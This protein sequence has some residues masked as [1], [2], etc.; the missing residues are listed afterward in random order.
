MV[1]AAS[2]LLHCLPTAKNRRK[3]KR[4]CQLTKILF[5]NPELYENDVSQREF[6]IIL[7]AVANDSKPAKKRKP[8]EWAYDVYEKGCHS[9]QQMLQCKWDTGVHESLT[10]QEKISI[11]QEFGYDTI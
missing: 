4:S 11:L 6:E 8:R 10:T 1:K 5:E 7:K 3:Y 9:L 2:V